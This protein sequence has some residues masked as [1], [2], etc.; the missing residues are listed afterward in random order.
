MATTNLWLNW[1]RSF[2]TVL[3]MIFGSGAVIA[4]LSS[5]EGARLYIAKQLD[6]L[7]T[8]LISINATTSSGLSSG[9][10]TLLEKYSDLFSTL[11]FVTDFSDH[12][13]RFGSKLGQSKVVG[14]ESNYFEA[15][16]LKLAR[17]RTFV[18]E[19]VEGQ[20]PVAVIGSE[21]RKRFFGGRGGIGETLVLY[22]GG[23]PKIAFAVEIVGAL[24]ERGGSTG[25][26]NFDSA[27]FL[28]FTL[29]V[30]LFGSNGAKATLIGTLKNEDESLLARRQIKDLLGL[31]YGPALEISDSRGAIEMT[32]SIWDKQNFVGICLAI[33]SLI[34]GGVGIMN[35]ML[36]SIHQR[37]REIGLRKAIG[38]RDFD[39]CMQFLFESVVVCLLGGCIGIFAGWVFGKQVAS[40][41]GQWEAVTNYRTILLA[42]VF[43]AITGLVFGLVP[44]LRASKLDPYDALRS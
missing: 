26:A 41:L 42:L 4:T 17:G 1:F 43:A 21:V 14:V 39:I 8:N 18:V 20:L 36:L 6:S 37:R 22:V 29:G 3:G 31:K 7:G 10:K 40:M 19:E 9:D 33:I 32:K 25:A 38:A 27:I 23:E 11:G 30:K 44:A 24:K 34:T 16:R 12:E 35:V 13:V 2:L 28:P 5:N 15:I